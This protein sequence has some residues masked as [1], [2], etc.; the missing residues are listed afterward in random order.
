[1]TALEQFDRL[2]AL[3]L[4]RPAPADEAREVL[5][6]FGKATLVLQTTD[7]APLT[8]WSLPALRLTETDDG[9]VVLTPDASGTETLTIHDPLMKDALIRVIGP[10]ATS[11]HKRRGTAAIWV[12]LL[13][14]AIGGAYWFSP[15]LL[16][17]AAQTLIAP[18]RRAILAEDLLERIATRTGPICANA[19]GA[20]ALL[21]FSGAVKT[22]GLARPTL[23]VADIGDRPFLSLPNRT[24]LLSRQIVEKAGSIGELH[25]WTRI[26]LGP[27]ARGEDL[28]GLF[29]RD[30]LADG[31]GFLA[32]GKVSERARNRLATEILLRPMADI[33]PTPN[34]ADAPALSDA[35]WVALQDICDD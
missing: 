20:R 25:S 5:V 9:G 29:A 2:E 31:I 7:D 27:D 19:Q 6:S 10:I 13:L 14:V 35:D 23:H 21:L 32:S 3:G 16:S 24:V 34:P 18:E 22:G 30:D 15:Q 28:T 4:W 12:V 1:M 11:G 33:T 17:K 26:A 8:H